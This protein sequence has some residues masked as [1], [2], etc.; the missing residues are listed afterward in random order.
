[1]RI[2]HPLV[3]DGSIDVVVSN[4]VLNLVKP[5][6]KARL[7]GE[8]L[9]VLKGGGR[10]ISDIVS[11]EDVPLDLRRDADQAVIYRGRSA[12]SSTTTGT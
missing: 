7:F 1:M 6:D 10:V 11:Y 3:A 5:A 2:E 9:R 12:R 4:C 8:L